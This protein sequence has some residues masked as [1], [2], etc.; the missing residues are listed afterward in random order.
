MATVVVLFEVSGEESDAER[1]VSERLDAAR[2]LW[3]NDSNDAD[4]GTLDP[5]RTFAVVPAR[6]LLDES[7]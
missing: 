7:L 6:R 5:V 2:L 1:I 3:Q 4:R